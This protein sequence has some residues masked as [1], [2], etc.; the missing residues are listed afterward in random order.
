MLGDLQEC[1]GKFQNYLTGVL[2]VIK[3]CIGSVLEETMICFSN[4]QRQIEEKFH[5]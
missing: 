5:M 2:S 4:I 1:P 3:K